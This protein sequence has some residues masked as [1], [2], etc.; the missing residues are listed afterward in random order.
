MLDTILEIPLDNKMKNLIL[1]LTVF[2]SGCGVTYCVNPEDITN[3]YSS[4]VTEWQ[5]QCRVA[6]DNA[7]KEVF[8]IAPAPKPVVDTDPD[9]AKCICKGTGIIVQGDGHKTVCPYHSKT[10]SKR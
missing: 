9:P 7:E 2:L 10:T 3:M 6:F 1:I 4:Y 5:E 8:K